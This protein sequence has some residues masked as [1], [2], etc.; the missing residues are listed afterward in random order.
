MKAITLRNLPPDVA[1]AV[2]GAAAEKGISLNRAVIALLEQAGG[3]A[4][5]KRPPREHRDL[6]AFFGVWSRRDAE[7]FGRSLADQ[8]PVDPEVWT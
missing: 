5:A 8:R 1:R 6:D 7:E 4:R 3:A 2:L